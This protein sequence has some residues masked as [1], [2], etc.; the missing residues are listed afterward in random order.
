MLFCRLITIIV[1]F[2]LANKCWAQPYYK[3]I[4]S[5]IPIMEQLNPL[6]LEN[7]DGDPELE[8]LYLHNNGG[9]VYSNN[10]TNPSFEDTLTFEENNYTKALEDINNDGLKDLLPYY[11]H[12]D[13]Y[14]Y[15]RV[16]QSEFEKVEIDT[17][18]FTEVKT[19]DF[20]GDH[21][22]DFIGR[23]EQGLYTYMSDGVDNFFP[24]PLDLQECNTCYIHPYLPVKLDND[25]LTDIVS[26]AYDE[27]EIYPIQIY[28]HYNLGNGQFTSF[29]QKST[30][31][32]VW[33]NQRKIFSSDLDNDG[34]LDLVFQT[35]SEVFLYENDN[36]VWNHKNILITKTYQTLTQLI[37][38]NNDGF[39]DFVFNDQ[40]ILKNQGDFNNFNELATELEG[41]FFNTID[42]DNDGDIDVYGINHYPDFELIY[43]ENLQGTDSLIIASYFV[44]D[45]FFQS[46][47]SD[48]TF[49]ES[50][51]F[52]DTTQSDSLV[53]M[54]INFHNNDTIKAKIT[55]CNNDNFTIGDSVYSSSG[56][57]FNTLQN[58]YGCDSL[59]FLELLVYP[60]INEQTIDTTIV[61][62]VIRVNGINYF[63]DIAFTDTLYNHFGCDSIVHYNLSFDAKEFDTSQFTSINLGTF[64]NNPDKIFLEDFDYDGDLDII[65]S[66]QDSK[67]YVLEQTSKNH[68]KDRNVSFNM[69]SSFEKKSPKLDASIKD[70]IT[71]KMNTFRILYKTLN[72]KLENSFSVNIPYS[73]GCYYENTIVYRTGDFNEDGLTD[74][75]IFRDCPSMTDV[76]LGLLL[77]TPDSLEDYTYKSLFHRHS[78]T[79]YQ[80]YILDVD[81]NDL[82]KDGNE[83]I[84]YTLNENNQG[85]KTSKIIGLYG[86]GNGE[87]SPSVISDCGY[88]NFIEPLNNN[89]FIT[90]IGSSNYGQIYDGHIDE[91]G[92]VSLQ[93]SD[94]PSPF[95]GQGSLREGSPGEAKKIDL[96]GDSDLD[97]ALKSIWF[98][99][100]N[101]IYERINDSTVVYN[102]ELSKTMSKVYENTD[103]DSDGDMDLLFNK[104]LLWLENNPNDTTLVRQPLFS[105][106]DSSFLPNS[107]YQPILVED[108]DDDGDKDVLYYATDNSYHLFKNINTVLFY[109]STI[110]FIPKTFLH[111]KDFDMDGDIDLIYAN[112]WLEN[113]GNFTFHKNP[114]PGNMTYPMQYVDWNNDGYIDVLAQYGDTISWFLNNGNN[115]FE[116]ELLISVKAGK[117][118]KSLEVRDFDRDGDLD[119]I[120]LQNKYSKTIGRFDNIYQHLYLNPLNKTSNDNN[121]GN[122]S[123]D[124]LNFIIYPNPNT[125]IFGIVSDVDHLKINV[126]TLE[127]KIIHIQNLNLGLNQIVLDQNPING[128]Y[129]ISVFDKG[130]WLTTEKIIIVN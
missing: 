69:M 12:H 25:S 108:L 47:Y 126:S 59:V 50:T 99:E 103:V 54:T 58:Q 55:I 72:S 52:I 38:L 104:G 3:T 102:P 127:G 31:E 80:Q 8:L 84:I 81:I 79:A 85:Q 63:E 13:F 123:I 114:L 116:E 64:I 66:T 100:Y 112:H 28:F 68:F 70:V 74:F 34:D 77:S 44:C 6:V 56:Q 43:H 107:N 21:L 105:L 106:N 94:I 62:W 101:I 76:H 97:I 11:N 5:G 2:I 35:G 67:L 51:Q 111:A 45:T 32:G 60:E 37:D 120:V 121:D 96:D 18:P 57:Y 42:A 86:K 95:L 4:T 29:L 22:L 16:N 26:I 118:T 117:Y 10:L 1:F 110:E 39:V 9:I 130:E 109:E 46:P 87:F 17:L 125:G 75:V 48:T 124:E 92:G 78:M 61:D 7:I 98:G 40:T 122:G 19:G 24:A 128:I 115:G 65:S 93:Y 91:N 71:Y 53:L 30:I 90:K 83:D 15:K 14:Y 73:G 82:N 41:V 88:V 49:T 129:F 113:Q 89:R 20:N 27:N 119:I 36:Y 23:N 33:S